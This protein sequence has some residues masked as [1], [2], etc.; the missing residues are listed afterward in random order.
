[1]RVMLDTNVLISALL[2]PS[3][4]MDKLFEKIFTEHTVV[5]STY[6]IDELYRVCKRKFDAKLVDIDNLLANMNYELVYTPHNIEEVL[7]DI[8]D[9]KDYPILHTAI[10]ED[11][12]VLI[13]GDKDFLDIDIDKPII[14]TPHEF[15]NNYDE[16]LAII[17]LVGELNSGHQSGEEEGW[18]LHEEVEAY[19]ARKF[20]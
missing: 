3:Q 10:L 14:F 16:I 7:V 1:M 13:T 19:F 20:K 12:D 8:R 18:L 4:H 17:S 9:Q 6:I 15:V 2:F 11:I 5:L